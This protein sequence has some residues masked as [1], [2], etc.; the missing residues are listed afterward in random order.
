MRFVKF[1]VS[2][3]N[4]LLKFMLMFC[5]AVQNGKNLLKTTDDLLI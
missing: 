3:D 4:P 5:L 2:F 1:V